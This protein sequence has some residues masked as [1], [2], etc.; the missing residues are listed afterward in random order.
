MK[1]VPFAVM[2]RSLLKE[3]KGDPSRAIDLSIG[4]ARQIAEVGGTFVTVW[5]NE[6]LSGQYEWK[7]WE[8]VFLRIVSEVRSMV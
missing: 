4:L 6:S 5:H 8:D 1:V 7:G 2:D 3:S